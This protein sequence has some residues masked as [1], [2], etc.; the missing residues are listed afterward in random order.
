ML[1]SDYCVFDI[2]TASACDIKLGSAP[3]AR[4]P[5]TKAL[6]A[7]FGFLDV[8]TGKVITHTWQAG[9]R[10]PAT[11]IA[12]FNAGLPVVAHNVSFELEIVQAGL[13]PGLPLPDPNAWHDTMALAAASNF[14]QGLDQLGEALGCGNKDK[15]G[16][17]VMRRMC[18]LD[19]SGNH[20]NNRKPFTPSRAD[21]DKLL[22]YCVKDV[23]MTAAIFM[24]LPDLSDEEREVWLADMRINRRGVHIDRQFC[25]GIHHL[26]GSAQSDLQ[27]RVRQASAFDLS[28]PRAKALKEF[29]VSRG[30]EVPRRRQPDGT[31][32]E[33]LDRES[34]TELLAH[35]FDIPKD[36]RDV[37]LARLEDSKLTS[38]AKVKAAPD[39]LVDG[40]RLPWQLRY[41]GAHTGRWTAKGLQIHNMPKDK[42]KQDHTDRVRDLVHA[43]DWPGLRDSED[44]PPAAL[45]QSLRGMITAPPGRELIGADYSA[46]EARV[47]AWL[48]FDTDTLN[49]FGSGRDI[50]V[51][52]A[53]AVGSDNRNLG[54]VQ[55][56]GLGYSMGAITFQATAT[57]YGVELSNKEAY[58][59]HRGWRENNKPIVEFW[60]QLEEGF[61][62]CANPDT[63]V[64]A[65]A[66]AGRCILRRG[67]NRILL[68]LPS[69]RVL[70]YWMPT[71][72]PS[73]QRFAFFNRAGEVEESEDE[74]PTL[75]YWAPGVH[76]M[77]E[78]T[79]YRGR[80]AENATQA[81][82]RDILANAILTVEPR[83]T[84]DLV[85]H[86]HDSLLAEVDEG[87]G[88][89][90]EFCDLITALPSWAA[91]LP[92]TAEG[93]RSDYF[94]G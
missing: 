83:P 90:D 92:L 67:E 70:S 52:D 81:V 66:P 15:T 7:A 17:Q 58:R 38:L 61:I 54:K 80:L 46:I 42:R 16:Y 78:T 12:W 51:E 48:A 59:V 26:V 10:M 14:P 23:A 50:Y 30:I 8:D 24:R 87:A 32:K 36:L 40:D 5:S 33:T 1:N 62:Y 4:H 44:N 39:R 35:P 71:V 9:E 91:G 74:V 55:R 86:V 82:A 31:W 88:D 18:T 89:V 28:S 73:R 22:A 93:Y 45:S 27:D 41:H 19:E 79:T 20:V 77:H 25:R 63:P 65:S 49:I 57:S 43:R 94:H 29:V 56:L 76:G 84:Y 75:F 68:V 21:K 47:L 2:E 53:A 64:G 85:M 13:L 11:A 69:G 34:I 3:Y 72:R 60:Q 37:L 6:C